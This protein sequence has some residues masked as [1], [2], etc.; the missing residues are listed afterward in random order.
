MYIILILLYQVPHLFECDAA[1]FTDPHV[2][3]IKYSDI[4][5]FLVFAPVKVFLTRLRIY[6]KFPS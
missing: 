3:T 6:N 5:H 1:A 4:I 2:I